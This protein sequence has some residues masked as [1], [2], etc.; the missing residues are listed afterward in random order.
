MK[1]GRYNGFNFTQGDTFTTAPAW[2]IGG[3]YVNVANYTAKMSLRKSPNSTTSTFDFS[4]ANGRIVAGTTDGKF[5]IT[6]S[7]ADTATVA[8]G[9]YYYDLE[10]TS[11]TSTKTTLLS[12]VLTVAKQVTV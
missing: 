1:A 7:S 6:A 5:T 12:G 4:T 3:S 8:S 9:T 10:V 2:K 11:P